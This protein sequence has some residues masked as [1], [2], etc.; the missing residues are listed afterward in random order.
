[1]NLSFKLSFSILLFLVTNQVNSQMSYKNGYVITLGNDTVRGLIKECGQIRSTNTCLFKAGKNME[2]TKYHP[3]DI[4]AY[5]IDGEKMYASKELFTKKAYQPEFLEVLLE[6]EINLYYYCRNK[7]MAFY[8]E[9]EFGT[10]IGL[11]NV[12]MAQTRYSK[13][14]YNDL[15]EA[16]Y[17]EIYKDTLYS[18]FK[19]CNDVLNQVNNLDYNQKALTDITRQYL[20][21]TC[22]PENCI[23]YVKN[24]NVLKSPVGFYSGIQLSKISTWD[25]KRKT[26]IMLSTPIAISFNFPV[27]KINEGLSIQTELVYRSIAYL[28]GDYSKADKSKTIAIPLLVKY[29]IPINKFNPSIG[30]GKEMIIIPKNNSTNGKQNGGYFFELGTSYRLNR[31]MLAFSNIRYQFLSYNSFG[32]ATS[33]KDVKDGDQYKTNMGG[34]YIG[35]NF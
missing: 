10:L 33:H 17:N 32:G 18:M 5:C 9:K 26:E 24:V 27:P 1:M 34:L 35:I 2:K 11:R 8:I 22:E 7:E 28:N 29:S 23:R 14:L 25:T 30:L 6:G 31:K 13:A 19:D 20:N 21:E 12:E 15:Y 4:K 3:G 16:S